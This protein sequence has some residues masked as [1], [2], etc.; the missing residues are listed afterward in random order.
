MPINPFGVEG[1][2]AQI[3]NSFAVI[4]EGERG[5]TDQKRTDWL[6]FVHFGAGFRLL[7]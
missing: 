7:H 1:R 2:T 5:K 3:R 6:K 4:R